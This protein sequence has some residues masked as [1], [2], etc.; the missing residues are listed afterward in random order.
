MR[1][2]L[3]TSIH[4]GLG[5]DTVNTMGAALRLYTGEPL[6][7]VPAYAAPL[8]PALPA[9][10]GLT[11]ADAAAQYAVAK[12]LKPRTI[13]EINTTVRK[14]GTWWSTVCT[15]NVHRSTR[16]MHAGHP[17][18]AG[19]SP[20]AAELGRDTLA[21]FLQW[22][23]SQAQTAGSGNPGRVANK[24]REH[25]RAVLTHLQ[26]TDQLAAMPKLPEAREQNSVAGL[27]F[28]TDAELELIYWAT[29]R[30]PRPRGW[31]GRV[32]FGAYW[33]AGLAVLITYGCDTQ[34]LWP[35]DTHGEPLKWRN[36]HPPGLAPDRQLRHT[37]DH[38]WLAWSRQKT[39]HKF[40][41]PLTDVVAAHLE[42]LRTKDLDPDSKIFAGS[43]GGRPCRLFQTLVELAG[44]KPK[45][46][47][48]SGAAEPWTL[49][50]LRKT[51]A[52]RH[53]ETTPGS[54]SVVLG[55]AGGDGLA[56]VTRTHYRNQAPLLFKAM[57]ALQ[58]PRAFRSVLDPTI[59]PPAPQLLAH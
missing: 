32:P 45:T 9:A 30:L 36:V 14:L 53:D 49:K 59:K 3:V 48:I 47:P 27:F 5:L 26:G 29:Y 52:T 46:D 20:R 28:L 1:Q 10:G 40:V 38:G 43:G 22:V 6:D 41:A 25:L 57:A 19:D 50:D 7:P 44:I 56:D 35:L 21:A 42:K 33:R 31:A 2:D 37:C 16:P 15:A 23:W 17:D 8:N 18:R 11:F 13:A 12:G 4:V 34:L 24:A 55:H 39:G 54:A 51:C 58:Y